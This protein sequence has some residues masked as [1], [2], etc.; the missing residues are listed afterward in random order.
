[1][2]IN[3]LTSL[4]LSR[5][6]ALYLCLYVC[7]FTHLSLSLSLSFS[8]SLMYIGN[9]DGKLAC[10]PRPQQALPPQSADPEISVAHNAEHEAVSAGEL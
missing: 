5:S 1:M 6:R 7:K 3:L 4:S 2:Y 8:L 9:H 10:E